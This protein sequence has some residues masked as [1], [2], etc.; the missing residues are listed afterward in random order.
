MQ[1]WMFSLLLTLPAT[2]LAGG[3]DD[4]QLSSLGEWDGV[5]VTDTG[6]TADAYQAVVRQLGAAI[7]NKPMLP[8][9]TLGASGMDASLSNSASFIHAYHKGE[10]TSWQRMHE[11]G[12]PTRVMWIPSL[13]VRKGLPL[14]LEAGASL[15]YIAFS[16]QTAF[17]GYGRWALIEG[18]RSFAPDLAVQV[19]YTGYV[20]NDELELGVLDMSTTISYTIPF[21]LLEGINQGAVTPYINLGLLKMRAEPRLSDADQAALGVSPVSG[22]KS[23]DNYA[24]GF[25]PFQGALGVQ[26]RSTDVVARTG[27][28][29]V[30]GANAEDARTKGE[31]P[32]LLTLSFS[33]GMEY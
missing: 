11:D 14:S 16:R 29:W 19:G 4:V 24:E 27:V 9:E 7:A 21:G 17:G 28:T 3:L 13:Q 1:R 15:G 8:A 20:G 2:A 32:G 6:L 26:I 12:D 31:P 25:S 10:P 30:P 33:V 23:S 22:F 18:Y 5:A